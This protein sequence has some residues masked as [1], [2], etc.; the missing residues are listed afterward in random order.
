[1]ILQD[2]P[3]GGLRGGRFSSYFAAYEAFK[4]ARADTPWLSA[5]VEADLLFGAGEL[6][7]RM[8]WLPGRDAVVEDL[9]EGGCA[10]VP[11]ADALVWLAWRGL[12]YT[13]VRERNVHA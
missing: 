10:V 7:V 2:H 4:R 3:R 13:D 9:A 8:P 5:I 12:I 6:C 11:V 1:M